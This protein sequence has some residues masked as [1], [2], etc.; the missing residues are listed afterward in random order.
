[1]REI[2]RKVVVHTVHIIPG[3]LQHAIT[4]AKARLLV[5]SSL[6]IDV[7]KKAAHTAKLS[8]K[9]SSNYSVGYCIG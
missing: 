2:R 3:E 7:A 6:T 5:A 8:R 9:V 1:M 4:H